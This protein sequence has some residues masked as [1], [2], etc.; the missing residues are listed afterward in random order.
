MTGIDLAPKGVAAEVLQNI[1]TILTTAK[2]SVPL[3]RGFGLDFKFVDQPIPVVQATLSS[4]IVG[5]IRRYEPR[6]EVV[7]VTFSGDGESGILVP[8]VQVRINES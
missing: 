6:A 8:K 1:Q 5:A 2:Y 7:S 3:D 4:D